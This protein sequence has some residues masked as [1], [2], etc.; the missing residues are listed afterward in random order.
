VGTSALVNTNNDTYIA[1]LFSEVEGFSKF[2][3]YTGNNS[4]DGPFV[5]CG[6]RPKYI[7]IKN[8]TSTGAPWLAYDS[9]R[10]SYNAQEAEIRPNTNEA[11]NGFTLIGS[12]DF[13]SNGFKI[14][15]DNNTSWLN[16]PSA[17]F[18]FAAFAESP[19]K[20]ARAR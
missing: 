10:S 2:G 14:R 13:L 19:F 11:E 8:A 1:Y 16:T 15:E 3:S 20:Y 4:T 5:W 7:L 6:F 9:V 17:T 18:I 12:L